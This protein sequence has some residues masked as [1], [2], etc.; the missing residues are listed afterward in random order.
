EGAVLTNR[1]VLEAIATQDRAGVWA[2]KWPDT[3]SI[4]F[5]GEDGAAVFTK[6]K[7]TGV[8]FAGPDPIN[9][10]IDFAHL[11][12][13]I[14]VVDPASDGANAP[15][16]RVIFEPD[17]AQPKPGHDVYVVGFPGEPKTWFFG[18]TPPAG[19]ETTQ[20]ISTVC[21]NNFGVKRLAPGTI[22]AGP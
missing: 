5:V 10:S 13:A 14:L 16:K 1:H 9:R 21:N 15:P 20:V 2:L 7:V 17:S 22:K 18:G 6:F 12:M 3:T 8:A 11:D 19:T 4:N